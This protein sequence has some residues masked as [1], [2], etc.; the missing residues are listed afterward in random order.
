MI[1]IEGTL[2]PPPPPAVPL[3]RERVRIQ[4]APAVPLRILPCEAGEGYHA[5]RGGGGG[6]PIN[7]ETR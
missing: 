6:S 3:P 5:K 1:P 4:V 2:P 7:R